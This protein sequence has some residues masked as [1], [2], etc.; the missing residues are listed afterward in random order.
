[1]SLLE[2]LTSYGARVWSGGFDLL[3][4]WHVLMKE[5]MS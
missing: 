4:T 3:E 2:A 1:M 5:G